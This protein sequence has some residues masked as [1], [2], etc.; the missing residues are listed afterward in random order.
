MLVR[1]IVIRNDMHIEFSGNV[2]IDLL[3]KGKKLLVTMS[4]LAI[5]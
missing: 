5:G 3:E 2:L 1:T 4:R